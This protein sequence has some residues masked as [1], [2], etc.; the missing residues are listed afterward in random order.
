MDM[1]IVNAGALPIY[2]DLDPELRERAG[3]DRDVLARVPVCRQ[4]ARDDIENC[5]NLLLKFP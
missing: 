5:P 1:G 3:V 4:T 2:D